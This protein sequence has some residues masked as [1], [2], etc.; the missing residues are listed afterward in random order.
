MRIS[1]KCGECGNELKIN[2][3]DKPEVDWLKVVCSEC[4]NVENISMIRVSAH[5]KIED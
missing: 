5:S 2:A 4:G 3:V 1:E